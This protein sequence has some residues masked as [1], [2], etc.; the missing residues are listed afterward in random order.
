M[1]EFDQFVKHI[2]KVKYYV[3]YTDDFLIIS[4]NNKYLEDLLP[5]LQLF[6]KEKLKLEIHPQKMSI[7]KYQR[8]IDFLGYIV[9]PHHKLIR[10]KTKKRI[11]RNLKLRV[12]DYKEGC[13]SEISLEQSI[14]SY[15]GVLSHADTHEFKEWLKN[16]IWFWLKN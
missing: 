7:E 2:L 16:K 15:L 4:D 14:Q 10:I 11:I 3:R 6:L 1:N 13:I 5:K 9:F 12:S 8:G